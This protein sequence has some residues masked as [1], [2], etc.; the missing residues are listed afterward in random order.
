M[1]KDVD[2]VRNSLELICD[3]RIAF[4]PSRNHL[5]DCHDILFLFSDRHHCIPYVIMLTLQCHTTSAA[6]IEVRYGTS[7]LQ[8]TEHSE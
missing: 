4:L 6:L 1:S 3:D 7:I 8:E 2:H 5:T